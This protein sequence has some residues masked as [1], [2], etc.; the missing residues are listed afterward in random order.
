MSSVTSDIIPLYAL[1]GM[2][3]VFECGDLIPEF[4]NK[5]NALHSLK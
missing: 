2:V 4:L 3:L 1:L 5:S